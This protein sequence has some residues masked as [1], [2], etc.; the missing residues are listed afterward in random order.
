MHQTPF[1]SSYTGMTA[2]GAQWLVEH[3]PGLQL[4]G[5]DYLSV[6]LHDDLSGAHYVF[7]PRV[8]YWL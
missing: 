6:G 3:L 1:D 2:D 7:L 4:V 5:I 8:S